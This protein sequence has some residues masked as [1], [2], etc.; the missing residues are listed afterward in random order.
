MI[1]V[2]NLIQADAVIFAMLTWCVW[3]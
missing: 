1:I 3:M 2:S